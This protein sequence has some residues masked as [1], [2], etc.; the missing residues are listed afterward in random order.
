VIR[1]AALGSGMALQQQQKIRTAEAP[2]PHCT[3]LATTTL[4]K[5]KAI[6]EKGKDQTEQDAADIARLKLDVTHKEYRA[7][8]P[9]KP[10]D[11][12][13]APKTFFIDIYP[14]KLFAK[15]VTQSGQDALKE[16]GL[17]ADGK[18]A[19]LGTR[20]AL[21]F[22]MPVMPDPEHLPKGFLMRQGPLG[23][24]R[25]CDDKCPDKIDS[26]ATD[27]LKTEEQVVPQLGQYVVMPLRNRMFENQTLT[28]EVGVDGAITKLGLKNDASAAPA[29]QTL[30]TNLDAITKAREAQEKAKADART[31]A[32]S[33]AKDNA[34]RVGAEASAIADCLKAQEA[35][36]QLGGVPSGRCQ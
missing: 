25:V 16:K 19:K 35:L 24:M 1:L 13:Q 20:V 9:A 7:W 34:T 6:Q 36:R 17:F 10:A 33:A 21:D 29:L 12:S 14:D 28:I 3:D 8:T 30:N 27:V 26:D 22:P 15:W 31:G 5:I 18:L 11:R 32:L 2:P 4:A 23:L